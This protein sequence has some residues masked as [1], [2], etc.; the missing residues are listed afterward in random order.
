MASLNDLL[1]QT[2]ASYEF[3]LDNPEDEFNY[4]YTEP[5]EQR[6]SFV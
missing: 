3:Y 1:R 2:Q 6:N 5:M 4:N